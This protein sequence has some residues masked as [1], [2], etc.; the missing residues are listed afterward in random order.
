MASIAKMFELPKLD[1]EYVG[2]EV[3]LERVTRPHT[4]DCN[5]W[6]VTGDD[7]LRDNGVEFLSNRPLDYSNMKQAMSELG[8]I[9][10]RYPESRASCR[11]GLHVH[12]NVSDLHHDQVKAMLMLSVLV[13]PGLIW[14]CGED[15]AAN[16][17]SL[18]SS[19]GDHILNQFQELITADSNGRFA[20][21]VA[22]AEG[23]KYSAINVGSIMGKGTIEYRMHRGTKS[24]KD[25]EDWT[26]I[27]IGLRRLAVQLQS[28]ERVMDSLDYVPEFMADY[29]L[30]PSCITTQSRRRGKLLMAPTNRRHK[31]REEPAPEEGHED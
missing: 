8:G 19:R 7:S 20:R 5:F 24:V 6:S 14:H 26:Y 28:V 23:Y 29:G 13:E 2:I 30:S 25:V 4:S 31:Y 12:I 1:G 10:E 22:G 18:A 21:A 27:L 11:T 9:F 3:E 15:R 17:Y 16:I